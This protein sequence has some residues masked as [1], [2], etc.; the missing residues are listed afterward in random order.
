MSGAAAVVAE[1]ESSRV[2]CTHAN[3]HEDGVRKLISGLVLLAACH[4]AAPVTRSTP[5]TSSNQVGATDPAGAVRGFLAAVSQQDLQAMSNL[6]GGPDGLARDQLGRP[7][8]EK[9]ELIMMC[10]LK[11]DRFD[12]LGEAPDP[13]GGRV[14]AVRLTLGQLSQS[15]NFH[16]IR[17]SQSRW[18]VVSFDIQQLQQFCAKR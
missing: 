4:T 18:Y 3:N 7:E 10:Y 5:V 9:R 15:T 17:G 8:L 11:H 1:S 2:R 13:T 12:I 16:V 6:W 14:L